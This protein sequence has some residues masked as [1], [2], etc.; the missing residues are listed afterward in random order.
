MKEIVTTALAVALSASLLACGR[1]DRQ[2][3]AGAAATETPKGAASAPIAGSDPAT[4]ATKGPLQ[5]GE[6]PAAGAQVPGGTTTG[7]RTTPDPK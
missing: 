3:K 7:A 2:E 4:G 1:D 6:P 5:T